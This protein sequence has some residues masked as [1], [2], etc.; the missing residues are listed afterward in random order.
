M[1]IQDVNT[2]GGRLI[3]QQEEAL[4]AAVVLWSAKAQTVSGMKQK[5]AS[6]RDLYSGEAKLQ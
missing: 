5:G 4:L 2:E 6:Q 3:N 1:W